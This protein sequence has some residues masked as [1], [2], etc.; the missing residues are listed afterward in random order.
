MRIMKKIDLGQAIGIL[1]NLGVLVGI[2][3]LVYELAQSREM[4]RAQTRNSVA[5]MVVNLLALEASDPGIA[6]LQVKRR[7]GEPLTAVEGERF[8]VL[9]AAYWRYRENVHYQYRNGLHDE[10]EYLALRAVWLRDLDTDELT[11]A[12]YCQS[13]SLG[14]QPQAFAGEINALMVR[15][16][17]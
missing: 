11:R 12:L 1:A 16:C 2:L 15:P 14:E 7:A 5:E 6:E 3:L 17:N 10:D 13:Q 9:Q 8:D 4:M